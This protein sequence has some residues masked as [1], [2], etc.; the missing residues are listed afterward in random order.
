VLTGRRPA[1]G[2]SPPP[3]Q[4]EGGRGAGRALWRWACAA[5]ADA[6]ASAAPANRYEAAV[7]GA[8]AGH[9]A[10][11]LPVCAGWEDEAWAYCRAWLDLG[12]D[13]RVA[14]EE[15]EARA[16][17]GA[18]DTAPA[19][20]PSVHTVRRR[21]AGW[22]TVCPCLRACVL[23]CVCVYACVRAWWTGACTRL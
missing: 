1:A 17:F 7:L 15:E 23:A 16:G 20:A 13:E 22:L 5:A 14:A 2:G 11:V 4:V 21:G 10:R 19:G 8:L 9:V 18:V 6:A 12:A 3:P